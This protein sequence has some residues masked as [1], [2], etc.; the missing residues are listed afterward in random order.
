MFDD[1]PTLSAP[2]SSELCDELEWYLST[3]PEQVTDV[4]GWWYEWRV[5]YPRLHRMALD[6]LTI[7]GL[8]QV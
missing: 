1:L 4:C 2:L 8:Y 6:Y 3:D 5:V 7:P